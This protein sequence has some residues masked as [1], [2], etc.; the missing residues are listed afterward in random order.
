M[1]CRIQDQPG[2][3]AVGGYV[4]RRATSDLGPGGK[5]EGPGWIALRKK[6]QRQTK[7]GSRS[8]WGSWRSRLV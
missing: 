6:R 8:L 4:L 3:A 1:K 5:A 7:G 2:V